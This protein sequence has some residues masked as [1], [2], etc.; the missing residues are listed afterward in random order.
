M[1]RH[2][3]PEAYSDVDTRVFPGISSGTPLSPL[4]ASGPRYD[5]TPAH[6]FETWWEDY[7]TAPI[8]A[9]NPETRSIPLAGRVDGW[10]NDHG[11]IPTHNQDQLREMEAWANEAQ[12]DL[13]KIFSYLIMIVLAVTVVCLMAMV[14]LSLVVTALAVAFA[15]VALAKAISR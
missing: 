4:Y 2:S 15:A 10:W 12:V 8:E 3:K 5:T 1:G 9:A 11:A 7:V 14:A 13:W 6:E